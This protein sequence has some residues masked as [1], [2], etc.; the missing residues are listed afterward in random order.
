MAGH[1]IP[2]PPLFTCLA[3]APADALHIFSFGVSFRVTGHFHCKYFAGQTLAEVPWLQGTKVFGIIPVAG[4]II[5]GLGHLLSPS[6]P[7]RGSF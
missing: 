4:G 6:L 1:A 5:E 7:A 2:C 3:E